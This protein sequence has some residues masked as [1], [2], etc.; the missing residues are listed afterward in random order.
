L[1]NFELLPTTSILLFPIESAARVELKKNT[2]LLGYE[3]VD[4]LINYV[5]LIHPRHTDLLFFRKTRISLKWKNGILG[6][7][8]RKSL[9]SFCLPPLIIIQTWTLEAI[10]FSFLQKVAD[11]FSFF[12]ARQVAFSG[13]RQHP[14]HLLLST[15]RR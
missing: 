6:K 8:D 10:E 14:R 2:F 12:S 1:N 15:T 5:T 11:P 3:M 9:A 7:D 13:N 4:F